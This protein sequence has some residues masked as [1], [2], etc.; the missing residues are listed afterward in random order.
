VHSLGGCTDGGTFGW[1]SGTFFVGMS[2]LI[3]YT[4]GLVGVFFIPLFF[5]AIRTL[6]ER[7][8]FRRSAR[9]VVPQVVP[10]AVEGD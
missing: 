9:D 4:T 3:K 1:L 10:V 8:L 2:T 5:T 7:G 6:S